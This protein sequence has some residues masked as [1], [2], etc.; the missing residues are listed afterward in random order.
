MRHAFLDRLAAVICAAPGRVVLALLAAAAIAGAWSVDRVRMDANTDSLMGDDQEY[1]RAYKGFL[2]EF[3]DLEYAW[4]VVD[5]TGPDGEPHLGEAQR[6]VD[7]LDARLRGSPHVDRVCSRVTA[8]E[9]MRLATWSMPD[10]DLRGPG[11]RG[12]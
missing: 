12:H 8:P 2:R 9:Q 3:G 11:P 1:V 7:L 6:A 4:I 5:T 10:A